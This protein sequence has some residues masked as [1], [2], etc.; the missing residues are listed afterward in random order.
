[1]AIRMLTNQRINHF[2]SPRPISHRHTINTDTTH[3]DG[4]GRRGRVDVTIRFQFI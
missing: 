4:N 1:M 2:R 3:T